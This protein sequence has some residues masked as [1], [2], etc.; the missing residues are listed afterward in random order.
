M[1][2]AVTLLALALVA[3]LVT[4]AFAGGNHGECKT[5]AAHATKAKLTAKEEKAAQQ[6]AS[7]N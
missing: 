4:A 1:K 7:A 5:D 6:V 2:P 3:G